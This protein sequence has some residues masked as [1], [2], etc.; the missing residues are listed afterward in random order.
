MYGICVCVGVC[1][2]QTHR[3]KLAVARR[4]LHF[5]ERMAQVSPGGSGLR[6]RLGFSWGTLYW[7]RSHMC[8]PQATEL[9]VH[10]GLSRACSVSS[11]WVVVWRW[12]LLQ[13][14]AAQLKREQQGCRFLGM[15][16]SLA[17]CGCSNPLM[18]AH[19]YVCATRWVLL[20]RQLVRSCRSCWRG[21]CTGGAQ[22]KQ[23]V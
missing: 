8:G 11:A 4:Q 10:M 14:T 1:V 19:V 6:C 13:C 16:C 15:S 9:H 2:L 5:A 7:V 22:N 12:V 3:V 23:H 17:V 18:Q 21:G 20:T